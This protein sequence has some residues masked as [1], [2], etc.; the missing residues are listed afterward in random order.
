M[1]VCHSVHAHVS[2]EVQGLI[3][4]KLISNTH[5]V[6]HNLLDL[7]ITFASDC[8]CCSACISLLF[9]TSSDIGHVLFCLVCLS[10]IFSNARICCFSCFL[11][12][13]GF[14]TVGQTKQAI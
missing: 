7:M 14:C 9:S 13:F 3:V 11:S 4:H 6:Q 10:Q 12:V 2:V 8:L 1:C 5:F